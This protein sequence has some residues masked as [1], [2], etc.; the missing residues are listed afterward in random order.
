[1]VLGPGPDVLNS[2]E[3]WSVGH[4]GNEGDLVGVTEELHCL[5]AMDSAVIPEDGKRLIGIKLIL[6]IL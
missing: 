6:Q 1:M 4:V 2:V 5:G 3:I